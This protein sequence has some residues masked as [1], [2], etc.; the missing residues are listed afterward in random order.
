MPADTPAANRLA[1]AEIGPGLDYCPAPIEAVG[2]P[3]SSLHRRPD[4]MAQ[5]FLLADHVEAPRPSNNAALNV[6]T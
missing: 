3:I 2:S 1:T 6:A 4:L 5:R